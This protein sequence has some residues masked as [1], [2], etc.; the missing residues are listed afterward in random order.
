MSETEF[1]EQIK[2]N[3]KGLRLFFTID[4]SS[5]S[6]LHQKVRRLLTGTIREASNGEPGEDGHP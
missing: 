2:E 4:P 6:I 3:K 5:T 1:V